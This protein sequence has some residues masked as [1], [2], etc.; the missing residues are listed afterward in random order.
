MT[1]PEQWAPIIRRCVMTERKILLDNIAVLLRPPEEIVDATPLLP[2][3]QRDRRT[4]A[5]NERGRVR[6]GQRRRRHRFDSA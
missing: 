1:T 6:M 4:R 5:P 3:P 2:G